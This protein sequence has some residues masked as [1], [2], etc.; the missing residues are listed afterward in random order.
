MNYPIFS[1]E[2]IDDECNLLESY[3]C[4][5]K[6]AIIIESM[7]ENGNQVIDVQYV[8]PQSQSKKKYL[9]GQRLLKNINK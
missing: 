3:R 8:Q 5:K 2:S 9:P 1:Y 4:D 6:Q 7:D